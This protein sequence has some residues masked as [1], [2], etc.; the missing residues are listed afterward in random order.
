VKTIGRAAFHDCR[1]LTNI[2]VLNPTPPNV[3]EN[4]FEGIKKSI[5]LYVP[6]ES[7]AKYKSAEYWK[8]FQNIMAIP[9][10]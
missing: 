1:K 5:P 8:E 3:S 6:A 10:Q 4:T 9:T 2:T 7:V